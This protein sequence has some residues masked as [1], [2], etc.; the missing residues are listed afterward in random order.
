MHF[1]GIYGTGDLNRINDMDLVVPIE[2]VNDLNKKT[3][4]INLCCN[5]VSVSK[6]NDRTYKPDIGLWLVDRG[7]KTNTA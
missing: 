1:F 2:L 3:K 4:N 7:E 6:M 5:W